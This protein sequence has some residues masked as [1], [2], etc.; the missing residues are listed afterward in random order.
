MSY[1]TV[2]FVSLVLGIDA[3][4][5]AI[6]IGLAGVRK[7][8]ILIVTGIVTLFHIFMPLLGLLLGNYLG[9]VA[10]PIAGKIGALVLITIGLSI[11]RGSLKS[12]WSTKKAVA[13]IDISSPVS[14]VV[15]ASSV[16]MDALSVGFGLGTLRVDLFLTVVTMGL[17][18]GLMT[19]GGLVFGRLLSKTFGEKAEFIGGLILVLIGVRL[20]FFS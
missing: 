5:V 8:G 4:S 12:P 2:L 1:L 10:E 16:S 15:M 13:S 6:G 9:R 19:A 18:A 14:L 20:L 3:F 11:S 17:V 7:K